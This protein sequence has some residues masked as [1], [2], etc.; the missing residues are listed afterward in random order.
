ML[1]QTQLHFYAPVVL[2]AIHA[3]RSCWSP[4]SQT[5]VQCVEQGGK[6]RLVVVTQRRLS[7][8]NAED[9]QSTPQVNAGGL[10]PWQGIRDRQEIARG[11]QGSVSTCMWNG[12]LVAVKMVDARYAAALEGEMGALKSLLHPNIVQAGLRCARSVFVHL[13][14]PGPPPECCALL[15]YSSM[16][17]RCSAFAMSPQPLSWS[18]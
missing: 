7:V 18:M 4:L 17:R 9:G 13:W 16:C 5:S 3:W 10:V 8:N 2:F 15:L 12:A 1:H 11:G 6:R 14:T